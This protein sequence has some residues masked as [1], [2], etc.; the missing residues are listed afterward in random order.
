MAEDK[1]GALSK[2]VKKGLSIFYAVLVLLII[3]DFFIPKH[4]YFP[5]EGYPSFYAVYG[6][7]SCV[8]L[9]LVAKYVLRKAVMREEEYYD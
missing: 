2:K 7:V 6:F 8:V 9:V 4:P 5:W 1:S 3:V